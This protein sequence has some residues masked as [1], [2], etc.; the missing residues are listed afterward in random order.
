MRRLVQVVAHE[1][2]AIGPAPQNC[3]HPTLNS[4]ARR[5]PWNGRLGTATTSVNASSCR[6]L[7]RAC[8]GTRPRA[9][10]DRRRAHGVNGYPVAWPAGRC[11]SSR[12]PCSTPSGGGPPGSPT[13]RTWIAW[14]ATSATS[15]TCRSSRWTPSPASSKPR[16]C[17][18]STRCCPG[19]STLSASPA[20]PA[21]TTSAPAPWPAACEAWPLG[22][23]SSS[24]VIT[25][26]PPRTTSR[27]ISATGWCAA[28]ASRRCARCVRSG[29]GARWK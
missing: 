14:R 28:T 17:R 13:S 7:S 22:F 8:S 4:R 11:S 16:R 19:R 12:R 20:G 6:H 2:D 1:V 9:G 27:T 23:R 18:A 26:R 29:P 10:R 24:A 21:C 3:R 25:P 15:R 5:C